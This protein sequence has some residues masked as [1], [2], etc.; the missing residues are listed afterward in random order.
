MPTYVALARLDE[1]MDVQHMARKTKYRTRT[2]GAHTAQEEVRLYRSE[3]SGV[4]HV[5]VANK[6]DACAD[7][8]EVRCCVVGDGSTACGWVVTHLATLCDGPCV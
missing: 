7:P 3:L 4:P 6:L 8:A 1:W 2:L 5:V